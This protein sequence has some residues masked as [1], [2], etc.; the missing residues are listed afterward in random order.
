M[1]LFLPDAAKD[2]ITD[3]KPELLRAMGAEVLIL[4]ADETLSSPD[5]QQPFEGAVKWVEEMKKEGF[6]A[7]V[8]SNN[9]KK[10]VEPFAAQFKLPYISMAMK[11][12][13]L[14]YFRAIRL[15]KSNRKKA[16]AIG[17]QI[18]T[19]ILGARLAGIQSILLSPRTKEGMEY[20]AFRRKMEI[21][22][23]RKIKEQCIG[24]QRKG[25][26]NK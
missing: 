8:V 5:S 25:L 9:F 2:K 14:G 20:Y 10:R 4:D 15:M 12:S 7:I 6:S 19:D 13:P 21:P 22:F 17:D 16:V 24:E 23:R 3:I 18:F 1:T 11:P 26:K